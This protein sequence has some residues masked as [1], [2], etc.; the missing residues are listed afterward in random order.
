MSQTKTKTKSVESEAEKEA[1]RAKRAATRAAR[2]AQSSTSRSAQASAVQ[3]VDAELATLSSTKQRLEAVRSSAP[4][5]LSDAAS[6]SQSIT[7]P[8]EVEHERQPGQL[9]ILPAGPSLQAEQ[10]A[11]AKQKHS[12]RASR[13]G[14]KSAASGAST[15]V[16]KNS[17]TKSTDGTTR[18]MKVRKHR[19]F[20]FCTAKD[21]TRN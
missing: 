4:S 20:C 2:K 16:K 15:G 19:Q 7:W 10:S 9:S 1:R 12:T 11:W 5:K 17:D 6:S 21:C 8:P 13:Y 18:F 14:A 3:A